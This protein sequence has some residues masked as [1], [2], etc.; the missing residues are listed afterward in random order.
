[1]IGF[2]DVE[3]V[4]PAVL[5]EMRYAGEHNFV[6]R[7]VRGYRQPV[8]LLTRAA[9]GGI[10]R[11]QR[12]LTPRGLTLK[13]YDCYRPRRA[14]DDF[15]SWARDLGDQR[16]KAEFY[17]RVDKRRLFAD[18]YIAQRSAH[19]RGSTVDLTIVRRPPARQERYRPGD[20]LRDCAAPRDER[21]GDNS[22]DMGTGYDCFDPR[23]HT[24]DPRIT[25]AARRNRLLLKRTMERAGFENYA[26]E[27]WHYTL[28]D[29]PHPQRSFDFPVSP[30]S[31]RRG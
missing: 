4:A 20:A 10:R 13:V 28:R 7:R 3:Q 25:G 22:L 11:A 14:V 12:Q 19:S 5:V 15:V 21:F 6:G 9:A 1:M 2:A 31:L 17:P 27:W 24:L 26:H 16:M 23:S 29:E 8:C 30:A 18:G